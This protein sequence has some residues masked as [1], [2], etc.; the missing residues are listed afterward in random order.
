LKEIRRLK[1]GVGKLLM[2]ASADYDPIGIHYSME[3]LYAALA[4]GT[5]AGASCSVHPFSQVLGESGLSYRL[6]APEQ[7]AAGALSG[8]KAL[9]LSA[10]QALSDNE[11]AAICRFVEAGGLVIADVRPGV[12]DEH[13][14][15][16]TAGVL[17]S[18]FGVKQD[19]ALV[20]KSTGSREVSVTEG[21]LGKVDKLSLDAGVCRDPAASDITCSVADGSSCFLVRRVGQGKA[22]L[23]NFAARGG[24]GLGK[25]LEP[26]FTEAGLKPRIIVED[27][28][29][30]RVGA[31]LPYREGKAYTLVL[32][33][34]ASYPQHVTLPAPAHCYLADE[35]RYLGLT[36]KPV[37]EE[38]RSLWRRV[39]VCLPYS[40]TQLAL[41]RSPGEHP[42]EHK[43]RIV[44]NVEGAPAGYHVIRFTATG[45]D[46]Q[47]RACYAANVA[48]DRGVG[49]HVLPLALNDPPGTWTAT[50]TDV[51]SGAKATV[52]WSVR[53]TT[54]CRLVAGRAD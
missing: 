46:G 3:S 38:D 22:V 40:V 5:P 39:L 17:D 30:N 20:G 44:L 2:H 53:G 52:R 9:L 14:K 13:G 29:G 35:G 11:A 16:R 12:T 27:D 50:A 15:V 26:L 10:S 1:S 54:L 8:Y 24:I 43:F 19:L 32:S 25:V 21:P 48:V 51:A 31:P 4:Y 45:P 28:K 33:G 6:V 47:E 41:T 34:P 23:L 42:G 18:L 37:V 7:I 49:E 36:D